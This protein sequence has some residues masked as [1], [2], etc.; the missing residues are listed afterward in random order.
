MLGEA[1]FQPYY[2][3]TFSGNGK[4]FS[5]PDVSIDLKELMKG[6]SMHYVTPH[7]VRAYER[8][9]GTFVAG[10]WRD[11]DGDTTIN[12]TI[13]YLRHNPISKIEKGLNI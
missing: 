8:K 1:V 3:Y 6:S 11:G 4:R 13:G 12:R 5:N 7:S 9:D 2:I 10:Y